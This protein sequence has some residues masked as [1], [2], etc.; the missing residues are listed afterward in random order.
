MKFLTVF[1]SGFHLALRTFSAP[2]CSTDVL[3]GRPF[4]FG[5]LCLGHFLSEGSAEL[6][7]PYSGA[8]LV[9]SVLLHL[10]CMSCWSEHCQGSAGLNPPVFF[11]NFLFL[12]HILVVPQYT[13][14]C[15]RT[16]YLLSLWGGLCLFAH[17]CFSSTK[18][19]TWPII[20][21]QQIYIF[22]LNGRGIELMYLKKIPPHL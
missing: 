13:S 18:L 4:C 3:S 21:T 10:W 11:R 6:C 15:N 8:V 7:P 12:T 22:L 17:C 14:S 5:S 2:C 1:A 19:G 16:S 20:G 9:L